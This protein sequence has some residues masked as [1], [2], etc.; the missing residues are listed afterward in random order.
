VRFGGKRMGRPPKE[1]EENKER[2]RE[3]KAQRIRDSRERIP[4]EGKFGQG[5][6]GYRLNYIRAKLQRTSEAWINCIF[7]VMNLMVLLRKLQE[8]LK[9]LFFSRSLSL[10]KLLKDIATR[11]GHPLGG[12]SGQALQYCLYERLD[13]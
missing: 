5:K 8:Q 11:F 13:F 9:K 3:L 1:T 2:L 6:N 7:L 12:M 4:I 10:R